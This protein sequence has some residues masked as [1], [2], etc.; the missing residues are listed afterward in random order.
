MR[1]VQFPDSYDCI[2]VSNG[3]VS[4]APILS[5]LPVAHVL[6]FISF[7]LDGKLHQCC[8][9]HWF[10]VFGD[11]PDPDNR[12]WIVIP[13]YSGG[14]PNLLVIHIDSIYTSLLGHVTST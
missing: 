5:N 6:L 13:K 7:S 11:K 12:M 3:S 2:F 4:D 1:Q 14:A 8:L 9:I 10:S